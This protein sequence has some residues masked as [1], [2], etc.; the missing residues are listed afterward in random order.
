MANPINSGPLDKIGVIVDTHRINVPTG[1]LR[2]A[3]NAIAD[4]VGEAGSIRKRPGLKK[5]NT[6]AGSGSVQGGTGVPLDLGSAGPIIN[7]PYT[8]VSVSI[9]NYTASTVSSTKKGQTTDDDSFVF[10]WDWYFDFIE[11]EEALVEPIDTDITDVADDTAKT[12]S[13]VPLTIFGD[14]NGKWF[15][16]LDDTLTQKTDSGTTYNNA[17]VLVFPTGKIRSGMTGFSTSG[18]GGNSP[19]EG[20]PACVWNNIL[21][22]A[23]GNYTVGSTPPPIRAYDGFSDKVVCRIPKNTDVSTTNECNFINSLFTAPNGKIYITTMDGGVVSASTGV[24]SVF[25]FDPVTNA[26]LKVGPTFA[27][28][29]IPYSLA[30]YLNALWVGTASNGSTGKVHTIHPGFDSAFNTDLTL[31]AGEACVSGLAVFQG[32]LYASTLNRTL[33]AVNLKLK[34]RTTLAVWSDSDTGTNDTNAG[35]IGWRGYHDVIVFPLENTG[36]PTP[37]ATIYATRQGAT[38]DVWNNK[39][40]RK[41]GAGTYSS[42]LVNANCGFR[43][44]SGYTV[45]SSTIKPVISVP[46]GGNLFNSTDGIT[47]TDRTANYTLGG[48]SHAMPPVILQVQL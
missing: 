33:G 1:T 15:L 21:F 40:V 35:H 7:N 20:H 4:P 22:Y 46:S 47:F 41:L 24:G 43:L 34:K 14:T 27:V 48:T 8:D 39:A 2:K 26:L 36:I 38:E 32:E 18:G 29:N 19:L 30:W 45:S 12:P 16:S 31:A 42:V 6:A 44:M 9:N 13:I 37:A 25:E 3:Q 23:D 11:E 17:Q 28:D 5:F 10:D